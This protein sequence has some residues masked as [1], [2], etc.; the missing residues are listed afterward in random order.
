[1]ERKGEQNLLGILDS[2]GNWSL[3]FRRS[4]AIGGGGGG[5]ERTRRRREDRVYDESWATR[6]VVGGDECQRARVYGARCREGS[7][8]CL[9]GGS[10]LF[11]PRGEMAAVNGTCGFGV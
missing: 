5:G 11:G 2:A 1:M 4:C 7:Q 8:P 3:G 9:V 10:W 6:S